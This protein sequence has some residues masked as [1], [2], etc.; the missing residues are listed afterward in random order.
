MQ[1]FQGIVIAH[2]SEETYAVLTALLL[3]AAM[4]C[5]DLR[6]GALH[7]LRI[8]DCLLH[9]WKDTEFGCDGDT[10]VC[11]KDIDWRARR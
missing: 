1:G 8:L 5:E 11:V 2:L 10:Q 9:R 4:A 7:H 6:A 3:G